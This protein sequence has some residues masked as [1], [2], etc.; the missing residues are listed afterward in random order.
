MSA[1]VSVADRAETSMEHSAGEREQGSVVDVEIVRDQA[2][3]LVK[4]VIP[5]RDRLD[6]LMTA[7]MGVLEGT[8]GVDAHLVI[9]DNGSRA[10]DTAAY[11]RDLEL[12]DDVTVLRIDEPFNFSRLINQG[13]AVGPEAPLLLLLNNDVEVLDSRWLAQLCSWMDDRDVVG[14]GPKLL[15][16]DGR[17]QHAGM[18]FGFGGIAGHYALGEERTPVIGPP[19]VPREVS[20]LTGACLLVRASDFAAIGGLDEDFETDFQDVDLCLRL[21]R[22]LQGDL[23]YDPTY[24]L[25]HHQMASRDPALA[26][27][28]STIAKMRAKW[29]S[30]LNEP[31]PFWNPHL[32][33]VPN[34]T[35]TDLR[36]SISNS[37]H[38]LVARTREITHRNPGS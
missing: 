13:A 3:A 24:P 37:A 22:E 11:L 35:L 20:C 26:G 29:G 9:V 5:T 25:I 28:D 10:A 16:P 19:D 36:A 21:R 7:V 30:V 18:V 1:G 12:R 14:V 6:L 2:K 34:E 8:V 17:I 32:S 33:V 31:D 38:R 27:S 15:F 4:I 23:V